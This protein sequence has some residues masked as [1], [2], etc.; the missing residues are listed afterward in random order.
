[1][2]KDTFVIKRKYDNLFLIHVNIRS[3]TSNFE[4][5][6][7]LFLNCLNYFKIICVTETWSTDKDIK[8]SFYQTLILYIK[9]EKLTKGGI[10]IYVKNHIKFKIIKEIPVSDGDSECLTVEME[11]KNSKNL[12]P[13]CCYRPPN[14]AIK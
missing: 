13:T 9:K 6:H 1:M 7:D 4:K 5:L 14:G 3:M 11:N 12:I 10:L 2:L 8:I